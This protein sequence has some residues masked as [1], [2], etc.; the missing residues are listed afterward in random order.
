MNRLC[1]IIFTLG[2][3]VPLIGS[4]GGT[5]ANHPPTLHV[6]SYD[7][8]ARPQLVG[9]VDNKEFALNLDVEKKTGMIV[10]CP[11]PGMSS[12]DIGKDYPVTVDLDHKRVSIEIPNY[13]PPTQQEYISGKTQ[14]RQNGTKKVVFLIDQMR[15]VKAR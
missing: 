9:I 3:T 8:C 12:K 13:D 11:N 7:A 6:V 2:F 10:A 5:K 14:G 1:V 15:E 4:V